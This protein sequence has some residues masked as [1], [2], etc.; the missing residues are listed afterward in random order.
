LT[1]NDLKTIFWTEIA[2]NIG[3]YEL[4]TEEQKEYFDPDYYCV[5]TEKGDKT[6]SV[7][8]NNEPKAGFDYTFHATT[9]TFPDIH[10]ETLLPNV[11]TLQDQMEAVE[12]VL[13]KP[14]ICS[15]IFGE[16]AGRSDQNEIEENSRI[17]II[18]QQPLADVDMGELPI[19]IFR[20][21]LLTNEER[22][23]G[24]NALS[25]NE[26]FERLANPETKIDFADGLKQLM[27]R[28]FNANVCL[29]DELAS[30]EEIP[31]KD[32]MNPPSQPV[33]KK[34]SRSPFGARATT[35]TP[36]FPK[37]PMQTRQTSVDISR[38]AH[39]RRQSLMQGTQK[40][41]KSSQRRVELFTSKSDSIVGKSSSS[42]EKK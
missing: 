42:S 28:N 41:P 23:N 39:R 7:L 1:T 18:A 12:N 33:R 26:V 20:E 11:T 4:L 9:S 14:T 37:S 10:D 3:Q 15:T 30:L 5:E 22:D 32:Q 6:L 8:E 21:I 19:E 36:L 27:Y 31:V 40:S 2:S 16:A 24:K 25:E 35:S 38:I 17:N 29:D 34:V 13:K